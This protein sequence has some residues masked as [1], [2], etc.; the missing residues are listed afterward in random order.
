MPLRILLGIFWGVPG[1]YHTAS[2]LTAQKHALGSRRRTSW[3]GGPKI[4][5]CSTCSQT[6]DGFLHLAMKTTRIL[7]WF[8]CEQRKV[9]IARFVSP[10]PRQLASIDHVSFHI[11]YHIIWGTPNSYLDY[12]ISPIVLIKNHHFCWLI[13][14]LGY[15]NNIGTPGWVKFQ[16]IRKPICISSTFRHRWSLCVHWL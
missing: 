5:S 12:H 4:H 11:S 7:R 10:R 6:L 13:P 14:F 9:S 15:Q 8:S 1:V 3:E 2:V 16:K